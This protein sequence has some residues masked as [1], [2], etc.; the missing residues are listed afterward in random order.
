MKTRRFCPQCGRP[1][2]KSYKKHQRFTCFCCGGFN[3]DTVLRT[4][5]MQLVRLIRR[6]CYSKDLQN[7]VTPVNFKK[8][9][10]KGGQGRKSFVDKDRYDRKS[11]L[12][13]NLSYDFEHYLFEED[14][15]KAND[16][17]RRIEKTRS[18][19]K[20][21]AGDLIRYTSQHGS[22]YPYAHIEESSG[23]QVYVCEHPQSPFVWK[24]RKSDTLYY[25][26]SGGSWFSMDAKKLKYAGKQLKWFWMWG[27]CGACGNGG[28][29]FAAEIS[30]WE[31]VE[32]DPLYGTFTTQ[33]WRKLY[34]SKCSEE[35]KAKSGYEF[36]GDYFA[37][38]TKEEFDDFITQ[39]KGTIYPGH[40]PDSYVI[41]CYFQKI[42]NMNHEEWDKLDFPVS[43]Y[44][45][46]SCLVKIETDDV[47]HCI[48]EYHCREYPF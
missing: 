19:T 3:P 28:V 16:M 9:Y 25:S 20:P 44:K 2:R 6:D 38:K 42:I 27:W 32:P 4:Q 15:V 34:I 26:T 40:W 39:Y 8:Y 31:Y 22:Y 47:N 5:D 33:K 13:Y 21:I 10:P 45:T 30:V 11:L 7:N 36:S 48:T 41:W 24:D 23:N 29:H 14:V 18:Y 46:H 43:K 1:L 17:I 37:F 12:S 35:Y